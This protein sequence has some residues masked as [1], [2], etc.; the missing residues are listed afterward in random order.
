MKTRFFVIAGTLAS[1]LATAG[2]QP[3]AKA[4]EPV[5]P[6]LTTVAATVRIRGIRWRWEPSSPATRP[7]SVFA[8]WDA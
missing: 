7:I 3:E 2:C 6:V 5:R 1:A 4:P 8:C